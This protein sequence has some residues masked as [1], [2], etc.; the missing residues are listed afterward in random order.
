MWAEAVGAEL[1]IRYLVATGVRDR[2]VRLYMDNTAV[3][4]GFRH[5][6]AAQDPDL[7]PVA[8]LRHHL[9]I[10]PLS[11]ASSL[12]AYDDP[13]GPF[14]SPAPSSWHVCAAR[15]QRQSSLCSTA[16]LSASEVARSCFCAGWPSSAKKRTAAGGWTRGQRTSA[17]IPV[18]SLLAYRKGEDG[19]L[20]TQNARLWLRL[21]R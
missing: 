15:P 14:P 12:F 16:I 1:G 5:G 18:C 11:E 21:R 9:E 6:L 10:S 13:V 8:A 17:L 20:G 7:C 19:L 4:A 3:E 2:R